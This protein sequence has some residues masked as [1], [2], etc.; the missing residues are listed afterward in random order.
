[1]GSDTKQTV[2]I[3]TLWS[4]DQASK[5]WK[6]LDEP[7]LLPQGSGVSF[8]CMETKLSVQAVGSVSVEEFEQEKGLKA[9]DKSIEA[10]DGRDTSEAEVF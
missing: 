4:G 2:Y 10:E 8:T 7:E 5:R 9:F 3:V 1:M 6:T